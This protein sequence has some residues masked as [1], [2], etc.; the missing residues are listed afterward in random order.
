MS[1]I[2][3]ERI[4][5]L[6]F[7]HF[8]SRIVIDWKSKD[9]EQFVSVRK[10][11]RTRCADITLVALYAAV[12]AVRVWPFLSE[13]RFWAEEASRFYPYIRTN[14]WYKGILFIY[15][16]HIEIATN[17]V[18][19]LSTL[20]CLRYAPLVT[21]YV[22]IIVQFIPVYILIKQRLR[23]GLDFYFLAVFIIITAGLPAS[24]EV[25][26]TAT[27]LHFHF[28]LLASIILVTP[29]Y[30][31]REAYIY[32]IL[33][34]VS[35][36]S[37]IPATLTTPFFAVQ[38]FRT[39]QR[40]KFIQFGLMATTA[41]VQIVLLVIFKNEVGARSLQPEPGVIALAV[42]AQQGLAPLLGYQVV[43]SLVPL[44][45]MALATDWH[46]VLFAIFC[47]LPLLGAF[48]EAIETRHAITIYLIFCSIF[49]SFFSLYGALG[50][51]TLYI[52]GS[53]IRYCFASTA[54][55]VI[56]LM[57]GFRY[58][59]SMLCAV[60]VVFMFINSV[61]TLVSE[62]TSP[63][64]FK[65]WDAAYSQAQAEHADVID[66]WPTGWTMKNFDK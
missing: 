23:F 24:A 34:L 25:W 58:R 32:R 65:S 51:R 38:A 26:G 10:M 5:L 13:G 39:R 53:G 8:S 66:I 28:C 50:T 9:Q 44:L 46:F 59:K 42:L 40:E 47:S 20:V 18:V 63:A 15:N 3:N 54:M 35:G 45:K 52:S 29:V 14:P 64:S 49:C 41:V 19:F 33:L 16:G 36:L 12:S 57:I 4:D 2:A 1:C 27:N 62:A 48:I 11:F 55:Q 61:N 43:D 31:R 60:C 17:I 7:V 56:P 6:N 37:G 21:T 30:S 22:S